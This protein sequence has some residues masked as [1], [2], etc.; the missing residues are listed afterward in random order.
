M[1]ESILL[2]GSNLG[3]RVSVL[4]KAISL[5][6]SKAGQISKKSYIY[7]TG[8]WGIEDQPAFLNQVVIIDTFLKPH[9]LLRVI[10]K[11]EEDLGRVRHK[12]W[13]E[14]LIDI[15]ILYY[16]NLVL[17]TPNLII[18]HPE[19]ANRAF[20]LVPLVEIAAD[21]VHPILGQPQIELLEKCSDRLKVN[22]FS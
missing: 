19:I 7:E 22:R 8:A 13:G 21:L 3:D 10:N 17:N 16:D 18:P 9:D 15:D 2:L 11:L 20:T 14:R 4:T 12:K 6:E 5:L 1:S